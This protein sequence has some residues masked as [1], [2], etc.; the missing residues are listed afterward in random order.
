[1]Q[2]K[3]KNFSSSK[4]RLL[5]KAPPRKRTAHRK[6]KSAVLTDTPEKDALAKEHEEKMSKKQKNDD[7]SK[8]KRKIKGKRKSKG[9]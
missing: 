7:K 4:V 6:R 1:L 9:K 3:L 5:S 8:E 2:N